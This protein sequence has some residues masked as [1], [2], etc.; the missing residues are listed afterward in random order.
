MNEIAALCREYHVQELSVF[1]SALRDDFRADSD[2]DLLVLFDPDAAIGFLEFAALQRKL[3]AVI[4]RPVDLVSK[5]GRHQVIR[6]GVLGSAEIIYH[7]L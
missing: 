6:D 1:G 5:R 3:A 2:L 7:Q 4:G